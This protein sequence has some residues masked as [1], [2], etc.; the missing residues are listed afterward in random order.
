M[1]KIILISLIT[2]FSSCAH[3]VNSYEPDLNT[4]NKIKSLSEDNGRIRQRII[5]Q[6]LNYNIDWDKVDSLYNVTYTK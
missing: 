5:L 2:L 6:Q 4:L 3:K 1:K